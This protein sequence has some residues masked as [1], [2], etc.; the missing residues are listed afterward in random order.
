MIYT[1]SVVMAIAAASLIVMQMLNIKHTAELQEKNF[2]MQAM[3]A[4]Q[5]V[6]ELINVAET[7]EFFLEEEKKDLPINYPEFI[8]NS[9]PNLPFSGFEQKSEIST[10]NTQESV[11][12][13]D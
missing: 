8:P 10:I 7:T 13:V 3:Q 5:D 4:L 9:D 1:L 12:R 11:A 6:T 2:S